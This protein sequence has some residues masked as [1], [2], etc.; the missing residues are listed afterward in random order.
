[1]AT[2]FPCPS[3]NGQL[4]FSPSK[5]KLVCQSC[6][7]SQ[8]VDSYKPN[9]QV[10]SSSINTRLY[11]CPNCNGEIQ[12][13][14][15]DGMEFCPFCGTQ[16]TM[17][18]NFSESG[19]PDFILPFFINKSEAIRKLQESTEKID[20]VPDGLTD[21]KNI[22]KIVGLYTPFYMYEYSISTDFTYK[23]N[24][25]V[26]TDT[27]Y[28]Y[29]D[30]DISG[31]VEA[32][33]I[34]IPFDASLSLDDKIVGKLGR[35]PVEKI[36]P[37]NPNYLAG[38]F[39][40]NSSTD[41]HLYSTDSLIKCRDFLQNRIAI[42]TDNFSPI[43]GNKSLQ[44][45]LEDNLEYKN[46]SG[47]YFPLYFLT[48]KHKNRVSYSIINGASG[49]VYTDVPVDKK[50]LF[51]TSMKV[52]TILFVFILLSSFLFKFSFYV[53]SLAFLA[54]LIS[55]IFAY[56]GAKNDSMEKLITKEKSHRHSLFW[57]LVISP[58]V[59]LCPFVLIWIFYSATWAFAMVFY[60]YS[61]VFFI[62][63]FLTLENNK[64]IGFYLS[65]LIGALSVA[66]YFLDFPEDLYY[67]GCLVAV[68]V[69]L[70][71]LMDFTINEYNKFATHPSPQF[72]K[73]GGK[74]ENVKS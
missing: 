34:Y 35:F 58:I 21:P 24:R 12:L 9:D 54:T 33:Q 44:Y 27:A 28:I 62:A 31:N 32:N 46:C 43:Q 73:K 29:E 40:E 72:S 67:Y 42:K 41:S 74:L 14:D 47:A 48:T 20:F 65:L 53:K 36:T 22:D 59:L 61:L 4:K 13:I 1:M 71:L 55:S 17:Q 39:V 63:A 10:H 16:A 38:F 68:F 19:N 49:E 11:V 56:L 45:T 57:V 64:N 7:G 69:A 5:N 25:T 60:Y 23:G 52:S 51:K 2:M 18:E 37:F 8:Y 6:G 30:A 3:C 70:A 26:T 15:N 66:I 50:K